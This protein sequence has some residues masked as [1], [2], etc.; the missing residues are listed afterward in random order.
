[1]IASRSFI[2][3]RWQICFIVS[4]LASTVELEQYARQRAIVRIKPF[5]VSCKDP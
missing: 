3:P 5:L 1:M 4:L 2:F